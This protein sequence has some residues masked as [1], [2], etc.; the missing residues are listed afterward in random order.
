MAKKLSM[1]CTVC[2]TIIQVPPDAEIL[3]C[4]TCGAKIELGVHS[5]R[6][7]T[8]GRPS[9]YCT[10]CAKE[11]CALTDGMMFS[12][13]SCGDHI[14]NVCSKIFEGKNYCPKCYS[15]LELEVKVTKKIAKKKPAKPK[16]TSKPRKISKPRKSKERKMQQTK[17]NQKSQKKKNSKTPHKPKSKIKTKAKTKKSKMEKRTKK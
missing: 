17:K 4:T 5:Y 1:P 14:C 2:G 10:S 8:S 11:L 16:K 3:C 7:E 13:N 15:K 6:S 9:I 12:C